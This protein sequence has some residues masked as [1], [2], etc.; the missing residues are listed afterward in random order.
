MLKRI[1]ITAIFTILTVHLP[2]QAQSKAAA[3]EEQIYITGTAALDAEQ[4]Q[5]AI[6]QFS[7]I[8]GPKGDGAAYWKAYAQNKLGQ[9]AAALE[10]IASLM[11]EYPR[12][13]WVQ[14]AKAL[15]VEIR[16]AAGVEIRGAAGQAAAPAADADDDLKLYAINSLISADPERAVPALEKLLAGSQSSRVKQRALFVLSQSKA[17]R[18]QDLMAKIARGEMYPDLQVKAIQNVGIS[19]NKKLLTDIYA[20]NAGANAKR[21]TINGLAIAGAREELR[22][23]YKDT[24]DRQMKRELIHSAAVTGDRDLLMSAAQDSDIEVKREAIRTLGISGGADNTTVLLNI[25][26]T[27]KDSR[28]RDAAIEGLFVRGDAHDLVELLKKETDPGMKKQLVSKLSVMGNKE[29]T[30]YLIQLL[31][32]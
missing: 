19:G 18:A 21:A 9:K 6:N 30:D 23:L 32:K 3:R 15:E 24:T 7:Q 29:A 13:A 20:S 4:W 22:Q 11:K 2:A 31:E 16:G 25:Y 26:N 5:T 14:D 10:T 17:P 27:E 8:Q 28:V 12:S 1:I